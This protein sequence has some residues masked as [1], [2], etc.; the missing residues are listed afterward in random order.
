M[1]SVSGVPGPRQQLEGMQARDVRLFLLPVAY[2]LGI[3]AVGTLAVG[4]VGLGA[5]LG[6]RDFRIG[7]HAELH[8]LAALRVP[9]DPGLAGGSYTQVQIVAVV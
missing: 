3:E 8:S 1:G 9:I 4:F 2:I 7:P 5:C 6:K